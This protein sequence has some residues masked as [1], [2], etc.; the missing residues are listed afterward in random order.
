MTT[1]RNKIRERHMT[2]NDILDRIVDGK[3]I[4]TGEYYDRVI[5]S[6][7]LG[8]ILGTTHKYTTKRVR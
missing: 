7:Q 3:V 4:D 8:L 5:M 2:S 6:Q 1:Q